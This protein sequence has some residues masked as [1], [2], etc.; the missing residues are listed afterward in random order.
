M[1]HDRWQHRELESI[2]V[3]PRSQTR[4]RKPY[5]HR[6]CST[7]SASKGWGALLW[8]MTDSLP[9]VVFSLYLSFSSHFLSFP[10]LSILSD[11]NTVRKSNTCEFVYFLFC[12][13]L[14]FTGIMYHL[15]LPFPCPSTAAIRIQQNA[16]GL[17]KSFMCSFI[18]VCI[19][20]CI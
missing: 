20:I 10:R 16:A 19:N 18:L 4:H 6:S 9:T 11:D 17:I 14:C 3:N 13:W 8:G 2:K 7:N 5:F 15:L 1:G 12:P